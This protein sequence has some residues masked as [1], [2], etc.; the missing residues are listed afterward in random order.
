MKLLFEIFPIVLFF[1]VYKFFGFYTATAALIV[2]CAAQLS[3]SWIKYRR[4]D[5]M[6]LVSGALAIILGATTLILQDEIFVK[7]KPSIFYWVFAIILFA[8]HFIGE[9]TIIQRMLES[10]IEAPVAVW[11]K[12]NM[13][14]AWFFTLLGFV[15]IYVIYNFSTNAWVNFKLGIVGITLIFAVAQAFYLARYIEQHKQQTPENN[16]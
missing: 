16:S 13:V 5:T 3:Y 15:N 11:P 7:W 6:L 1:V 9:K 14:W 2:G 8:S 4:V 10:N 12:L